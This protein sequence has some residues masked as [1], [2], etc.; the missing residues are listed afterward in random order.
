ME[1]SF[2]RILKV[3]KKQVI[4]Y[5]FPTPPW[6]P[7]AKLRAADLAL[8]YSRAALGQAHRAGAAAVTEIHWNTLEYTGIH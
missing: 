8:W 1:D 7:G 6:I 4:C 2:Y 5:P 3:K